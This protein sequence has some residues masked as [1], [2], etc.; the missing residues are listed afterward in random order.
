[1]KSTY[2]KDICIG[3]I[4]A[5]VAIACF[6]FGQTRTLTPGLVTV[7]GASQVFL[8]DGGCLFSASGVQLDDLP[9]NSN[10]YAFNGA[11]CAT[12]RTAALKAAVIDAKVNDGGVP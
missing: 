5:C 8:A 3:L 2:L 6:C 1:M 12:L 4:I 11:R 10:G 7:N 9:V